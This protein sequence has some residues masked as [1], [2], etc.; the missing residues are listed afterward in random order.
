[1]RRG[2]RP[3]ILL[4]MADQMSARATGPY[5]NP[6]VLTPYMD[7]MS[8]AGTVFERSYCNAPL[9]VPSRASVMTGMLSSEIP[10]NDNGEGLPA[11]VPTFVHHLRRGGYETVLSGKMHFIGPD[12]LHGFERRLTTDVYPSDFLWTPSWA[13]L[14]HLVGLVERGG[15]AGP[16]RPLAAAALRRSGPVAWSEQ[17]SYDEEVQFRALEWLRQSLHR[18]EDRPWFLCVSYT[19]PHDPYLALP[20]YWDRYA[21][22]DI[23]MPLAA[24]A[25][26]SPPHAADNWVDVHHGLDSVEPTPDEVYRSRRGYY[27]SVSYVDDKL[28]QLVDEVAR[29]GLEGETLVIFTSDHGDQ[30][31][32][33]GM[34]FKRTCREWSARVP[35]IM[36]GPDIPSGLRVKANA[37]LVDL[38]PTVI[39][40][41]RLRMPPGYESFAPEPA[42]KSLIPWLAP[43]SPADSGDDVTVEYNG[44]GTVEPIR[45]LVS[46]DHKFVL[47]RGAPDQ[48]FDL[49][50]DP[51]EWFNLAEEAAHRDVAAKLKAKILAGWDPDVTEHR[52]VSSQRRRVFLN[53]SLYQGSPTAW[54]FQPWFDARE[55]YSRPDR[56]RHWA[57]LVYQRVL[58]DSHEQTGL[59][60]DA[61]GDSRVE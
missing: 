34:W 33:H 20:E 55:M 10:V 28:G 8:Q 37:S 54:D 4:V 23:T 26:A 35:L 1:M 49:E 32:E 9:C 47:T 61:S 48:L 27:S 44:D 14:R 39:E 59:L 45:A 36:S 25:G 30:C 12:Q 16:H 7:R 52:V 40:A 57:S 31:G 15:E 6:D 22:Q 41:A 56:S 18:K 2:D 50:Q 60:E 11:A 13:R 38:F 21:N 43:G 58:I 5:G 3:N 24:P 29:L 19:H 17:L 46:G 42:G 53:E 51:D